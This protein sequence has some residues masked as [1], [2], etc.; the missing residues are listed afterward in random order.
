LDWLIFHLVGD[1][2]TQYWYNVQCK[3]FGYVKNKK[4]E[5]IVASV[6]LRVRDIP[7]SNVLLCPS[8]ED[9]AYVASINHT[10]KVVWTIHV[11]SSEWPQ[12]DCPFAK[13][14]IACKHVMKIFKMLHPNI[15]NGA[16]VRNTGTFHGINK[17]PPTARHMVCDDLLDQQLDIDPK[18]EDVGILKMTTTVA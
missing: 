3:L 18:N 11:P 13:Q 16:I 14:G 5:G 15:P 10:P 9:I 1:V 2:L 4:Q 8:G 6:M 17:G 7:Y 12:F